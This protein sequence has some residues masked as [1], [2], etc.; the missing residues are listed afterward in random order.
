MAAKKDYLTLDDFDYQG[1]TVLLR[2]D[3]NSPVD[4]K[5]KRIVN[6]NRIDKSLPTI[7]KL[8]DSGAKLVMI[9]H[10]GDTLD[11]QNLISLREHAEKL[12]QK[13]EKQV[14]FIDDTA[15]PAAREKIKN[16]KEG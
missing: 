4:P 9:A 12:S 6:E 10:Q 8:T 16:L 1:K 13:L 7:K 15:G 2:V 5:T 11:Y 3:I 14:Q